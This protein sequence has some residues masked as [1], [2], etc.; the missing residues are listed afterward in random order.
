MTALALPLLAACSSNEKKY[1]QAIADYIQTDK[2]GVW[3][4]LKFKVI[5]MDATNCTV[6]DS[7]RI[8]MEDAEEEKREAIA[9]EET[10]LQYMKKK[11]ENE[12]GARIR[13]KVVIDIYERNIAFSEQRLDSLRKIDASEARSYVG[14]DSDILLAIYVTCKYGI[15]NPWRNAYQERTETFVLTPDG[16]KVIGKERMRKN[17][18]PQ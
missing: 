16:G 18:L 5:S 4:D 11:L 10:S 14:L 15:V 6:A 1:E 3:T 12:M 8:L 17:F 7:I 9:T 2:R 13:S